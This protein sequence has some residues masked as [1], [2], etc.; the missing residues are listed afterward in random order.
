M[1]QTWQNSQ[2]PWLSKKR[3]TCGCEGLSLDG[4][5][6]PVC[7]HCVCQAE[8]TQLPGW[9]EFEGVT[10]GNVWFVER[11]NVSLS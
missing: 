5:R 11:H 1:L 3:D 4:D 6:P 9:L 8:R 10:L 2:S 7:Q